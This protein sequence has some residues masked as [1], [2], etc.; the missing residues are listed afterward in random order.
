[1][2]YVLL[3]LISG[4][5][6]LWMVPMIKERTHLLVIS[7]IEYIYVPCYDTWMLRHMEH[8]NTKMVKEYGGGDGSLEKCW[9]Y[10]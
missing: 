4:Q 10:L 6:M 9:W 1:M 2:V 8:D 3:N 5:C 7:N